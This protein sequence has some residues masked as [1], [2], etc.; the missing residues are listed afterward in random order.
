MPWWEDS[1]T[2]PVQ[3]A[4]GWF[5][6]T[7]PPPPPKQELR[8][9]E[10]FLA[11]VKPEMLD[12]QGKFKG[13]D[14][15][16]NFQ[17]QGL[18]IDG[19]YNTAKEM[20]ERGDW[21]EDNRLGKTNATYQ[22]NQ[23]LDAGWREGPDNG[24]G[25]L[26]GVTRATTSLAKGIAENPALMAAITAGVAPSLTSGVQSA[27]GWSGATSKLAANGIIN[28]A[29][30][31]ATGGNLADVAKSAALSTAGGMAGNYVGNAVSDATGSSVAAKI[32][33]DLAKSAVSGKDLASTLVTSGMNAAVGEITDA[34]PG[35]KDLS[36][37]QKGIIGSA[38]AASLK[39][40]NITTA[41]VSDLINQA[42][43]EVAK[44]KSGGKTQAKTGGWA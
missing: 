39:G 18:T 41:V 23:L 43:E 22:A 27:T 36:D 33:S 6:D 32:A 2:S 20:H 15:G 16:V 30:T 8:T 21:S 4:A 14:A 3:Q 12:A 34:V 25:F 40:K 19:A 37:T 29:R 17:L 11:T 28:G 24:G 35:F 10:Q 1:S 42:T 38:I 5:N 31:L 7:P 13:P 26:S 44:A 9:K